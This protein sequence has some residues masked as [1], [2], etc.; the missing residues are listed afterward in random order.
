MFKKLITLYFYTLGLE[1][2]IAKNEINYMFVQCPIQ[3][4]R[5]LNNILR[6]MNAD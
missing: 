5:P 6:E 3:S 2:S 1:L 4:D